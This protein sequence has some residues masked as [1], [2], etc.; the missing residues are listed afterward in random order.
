MVVQPIKKVFKL[1]SES[2][3]V[4]RF[5]YYSVSQD[6]LQINSYKNSVRNPLRIPILELSRNYH[7]KPLRI[8][9]RM[10]ATFL[11]DS[12]IGYHKNLLCHQNP[13]K[14]QDPQNKSESW[15]ESCK[16][17]HQIPLRITTKILAWFILEPSHKILYFI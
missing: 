3:T 8:L 15:W 7:Q 9:I 5:V 17:F 6:S 16:Y 2:R 12:L 11:S 1:W 13:L 10:V 14:N 4:E